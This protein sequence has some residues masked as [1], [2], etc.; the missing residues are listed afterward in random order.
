MTVT[1][2]FNGRGAALG[3]STQGMYRCL[4]H[5]MADRVPQLSNMVDAD[6]RRSYN[7]EGWPIETLKA[8][9]REA[10]FHLSRNTRLSFYVDALDEG[11]DEDQVRDMAEFF[12]ETAQRALSDDIPFY[13]CLASRHYPKIS[14]RLSEELRLDD[15][16]G[17]HND[18]ASYAHDKLRLGNV[19]LEQVLATDIRHKSSGVFLWVVLVV[20]ILNKECDRGNQHLLRAQLQR[21]PTGLYDLLEE[22]RN[23]DAS[24]ERFLPAIRWVLLARRPLKPQELY[25]AILAST[26]QLTSKSVFWNQQIINAS[27]INDFIVSS[28]KG[29]VEIGGETEDLEWKPISNARHKQ[30]FSRK[31]HFI[32]EVVREYLLK[33]GLAKLKPEALDHAIA[34]SHQHLSKCCRTYIR[35]AYNPKPTPKVEHSSDSDEKL[36]RIAKKSFPFLKYALEGVLDHASLATQMGK[37]VIRLAER[38]PWDQW[39]FH[40]RSNAHR[41]MYT[42]LH[43]ITYEDYP[44]LIKDELTLLKG[45]IKD[46]R[47]G[48]EEFQSM[49]DACSEGLGSALHIAATQTAQTA[50]LE[51]LLD[52]GA[53]I[54]NFCERVGKPLH[55][56]VGFNNLAATCS[57]LEHGASAN[58]LDQFGSGILADA[59]NNH[60]LMTILLKH[61]A[62]A[63]AQRHG[64]NTALRRVH[65]TDNTNS[66][67]SIRM[68]LANGVDPNSAV[69]PG[70]TLLH[71][72]ITKTLFNTV[73][74]LLEG[75]A[76]MHR[77]I[78]KYGNAVQTAGRGNN[79]RIMKILSD[80]GADVDPEDFSV[81]GPYLD[82]SAAQRN[83]RAYLPAR[84]SF[85]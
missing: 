51:I 77:C 78:G 37:R 43:L 53:D 31:V 65:R 18:V 4:L 74:V 8:M 56:A 20:A 39:I 13:V 68:L 30:K 6:E 50:C 62:D 14:V 29:L 32:H 79:W 21:F 49:L 9:F 57:L 67:V 10:A 71:F 54:N 11:D 15:H 3:K 2:F 76:D 38:F 22:I 60:D 45:R 23:Q 85:G 40:K 7:A 84:K 27:T 58:T 26:R 44:H 34:T 36:S 19:R 75:G 80:F 61:G 82:P 47:R 33:H 12:Y 63:N 41:R 48:K 24:D 73:G 72:A 17:H 28:S 55:S 25:Y 83:R 64:M 1:F 16:D 69:E 46:S 35:R 52:S 70:H 66:M 42:W 5:Q 81:G 59:V